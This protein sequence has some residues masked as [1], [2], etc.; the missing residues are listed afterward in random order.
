MDEIKAILFD[1]DG[2]IVDTEAC[3]LESVK[4]TLKVELGDDNPD[5]D[6][7][8]SLIGLPS[9]DQFAHYTDDPKKV[10][11]MVS[12]YREHNHKIVDSMTKNFEGMPQ[13]LDELEKK[14]Y[15]IGIVTS[16]V[17][18]LCEQGLNKMGIR[19]YFKY[20]QGNEDWPVHKPDPGALSYACE[21]IG[22]DP[23]YVVYVG[24]S[25]FDIQSASGA[26]CKTCA[27]TWGVTDFDT[28]EKENPTFIAEHPSDLLKFF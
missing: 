18:N 4:H 24:D 7:F 13:A 6:Y 5:L 15:F 1:N 28:M 8:K 12:T 20:I 26:G 10:E 14:G 23:K 19:K 25:V 17:H 11:S 2:T 16:K 22:F 3:I 21:Q 9:E 27:V